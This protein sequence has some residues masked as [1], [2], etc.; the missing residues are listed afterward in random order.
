L[1]DELLDSSVDEKGLDLFLDILKE[2]IKKY[3]ECVYIISHRKESIK[4]ATGDI[5]FLEKKND[6][7]RRVDFKQYA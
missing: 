4:S 7:T 6:I 5:V 3:N 1:Y 2:R